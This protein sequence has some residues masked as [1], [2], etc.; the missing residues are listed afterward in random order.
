MGSFA[1]ALGRLSRA[2]LETESANILKTAAANKRGLSAALDATL[3]QG[4]DM[5]AFGLGTCASMASVARYARFTASMHAVYGA[6]ERRL[7]EAPASSPNGLVWGRHGDVLRRAEKLA[8]D[9]GDVEPGALAILDASPATRAY[10]DGIHAAADADARDGSGRLLGH[11]Y[12][13]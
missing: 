12:C 5:T 7:D 6:M 1:K 9:L 10:V 3:K 4:H 13:R 2:S 8:A 11:L